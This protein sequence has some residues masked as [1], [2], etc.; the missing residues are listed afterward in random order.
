[1]A[2]LNIALQGVGLMRVRISQQCE[3]LLS[4]CNNMNSIRASLKEAIAYSLEPIHVLLDSLFV[5][6]KIK[7]HP[8]GIF[9]SASSQEMDAVWNAV[10]EIDSSLTPLY[11]SD[12]SAATIIT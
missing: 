5:K 8:F 4:S 9:H 1:M 2:V 11:S 3:C 6:L 12:L 7:E 10:L